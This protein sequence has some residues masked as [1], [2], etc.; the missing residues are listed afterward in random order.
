MPK[1]NLDITG[2]Y[3]IWTS[4]MGGDRMD[5]FLVKIPAQKLLDK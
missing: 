2:Q 1:G 5:L 3:F 4:N